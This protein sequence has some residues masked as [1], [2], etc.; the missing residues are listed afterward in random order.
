MYKKQLLVQWQYDIKNR[1]LNYLLNT[2]NLQT[3]YNIY[4][5]FCDLLTLSLSHKV[6]VFGLDEGVTE[7]HQ[8]PKSLSWRSMILELKDFFLFFAERSMMLTVNYSSPWHPV[9]AIFNR[10]SITVY[11]LLFSS[12]LSN[13][14]LYPN[15]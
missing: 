15:L 7:S 2:E 8:C 5:P 12:L 10:C 11:T 1:S 3:L 6:D 9:M 14:T 4:L 13:S